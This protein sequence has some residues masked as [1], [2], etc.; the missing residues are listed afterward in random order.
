MLRLTIDLRLLFPVRRRHH[1]AMPVTPMISGRGRRMKAL[2]ECGIEEE[3]QVHS[4]RTPTPQLLE[5]MTLPPQSQSLLGPHSTQ[6]P[7]HIKVYG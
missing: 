2:M 7:S 1:R 5:R 6:A 3:A 4:L